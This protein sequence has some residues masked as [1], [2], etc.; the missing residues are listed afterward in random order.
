MCV[1]YVC[2]DYECVDYVFADYEC[3]AHDCACAFAFAVADTFG[4]FAV[5][6]GHCFAAVAEFAAVWF[7]REIACAAGASASVVCAEGLSGDY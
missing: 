5:V 2:V 7:I 1:D 6:F 4:L 3:A